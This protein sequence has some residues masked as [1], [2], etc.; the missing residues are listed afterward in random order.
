[1]KRISRIE[2]ENARAYYDR[3][4]FA[5][6]KGE[7]M[8]LYGEN[9]SGKSSLYKSVNDFIQSFYAAVDYTPNRY[10]AA[11]DTT[12]IMLR[13]G[14]FDPANRAFSNEVDYKFGVGVDN[15]NV[16]S[17]SF[18]KSLALTKGFLNYRD[19]LKVYLY[20]EEDP[21]L[22]NFFVLNL[23]KN[24]VPIA[25]GLSK[26]LLKEWEELGHD[27]K[28]PYN[29]NT[30]RHQKGLARLDNFEAVLRAL[31]TNLF[32][33]VNKYLSVY[34]PN[35]NLQIGFELSPLSFVYTYWKIDW[36]IKNV[37]KLKVS[38]GNSQITDY[39]EGLNEARL[40]A[41]AICLY[42]A[43]LKANPGKDLRLMFLD[44]IFIGIDSSNR[45]PILKILNREFKDFQIIIATYDRSWYCLA[46][47][48]LE[49]EN[50][51]AWKFT[52]LFALPKTEN[53]FT[54]VEPVVVDGNSVLD[55]ARQYLHGNRP[56]DLPAASN[57][58]RK[59]LEEMLNNRTHLPKE[60]FLSHDYTHIPGFKLTQNVKALSD[61]FAKTGMD[62]S[63][64]RVIETYLNPLIHPLSHYE[65]EAPIY[66]NE[67]ILIEKAITGLAKQ[68]EGLKKRCRLMKGKGNV[69]CI[70]YNTADGSYRSNRFVLLEDNLWLY[71]DDAGNP[72]IT[73]CK[74]KMVLMDGEEN[75]RKLLTYKPSS[76]T[77]MKYE[78]L[79]EALQQIYD[80][81]VN[82]NHHNVVP[83][84]D[85]DNVF[86]T[87]D[88]K[89]SSCIQQRKNAL[90][91]IM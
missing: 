55:K 89:I 32:V 77:K 46:K 39:T 80:F 9:G 11:G 41:I 45:F 28:D 18:L 20:D 86:F 48:Y 69:L 54:F 71:K 91:V 16:Q 53:G 29:R 33:E 49:K 19:L 38:S 72:K 21:N 26:T 34:F 68:I 8:L 75:G 10:K 47:N 81:E 25:Q 24:H 15:T 17:T 12:E 52:S 63:N 61:L 44:D 85:Y 3:K 83:S 51:E 58:F 2:I 37:L 43:A 42:L 30:N 27:L 84:T 1:M 66:R 7:N 79:D 65:E 6:D 50:P 56:I 88:M 60:L 78:S 5:L 40:S 23:L 14:D 76:N 74:C 90:L 36:Y 13:I 82:S 31:L 87:E 62:M 64:I 4:T 22:F 35:F 67:L 70:Q 57:Y 59:G 73:N